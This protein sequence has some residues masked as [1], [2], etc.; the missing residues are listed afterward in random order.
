MVTSCSH[1]NFMDETA[2]RGWGLDRDRNLCSTYFKVLV[3]VVPELFTG[4]K[5]LISWTA[6]KYRSGVHFL[7][8]KNNKYNIFDPHPCINKVHSYILYKELFN[9]NVT[10]RGREGDTQ[11]FL[12]L[13][14]CSE[15][16]SGLFMEKDKS[17]QYP[18]DKPIKVKWFA[19]V[20]S[21]II[22]S[23]KNGWWLFGAFLT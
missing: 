22:F 7:Q 4:S 11:Q 14:K 23:G 13:P 10:S 6:V 12:M 8:R 2:V 20:D 3:M 19:Q 1:S 15:L 16:H 21:F 5:I 9:N 17:V 18:F